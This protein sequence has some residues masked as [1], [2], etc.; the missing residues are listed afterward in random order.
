M[1]EN[2][3]SSLNIS[4]ESIEVKAMPAESG[5]RSGSSSSTPRRN[6]ALDRPKVS[7]VIKRLPRSSGSRGPSPS[8]RGQGS[9]DY[10]MEG[11]SHQELHLHDER[12]I[13]QEVRMHDD[14]AQTVNVGIDS[15][16]HARVINEARSMLE[17]S[18][19]KSRPLEGLAQSVCRF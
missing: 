3:S 10:P 6:L 9:C 17:E 13:E 15:V 12:S 1:S 14:L 11:Q 4:S 18:E 2:N 19:S 8:H 5:R 7:S 16:E